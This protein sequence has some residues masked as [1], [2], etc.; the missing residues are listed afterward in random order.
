MGKYIKIDLILLALF[1]G[2]ITNIVV[3][4]FVDVNNYPTTSLCTGVDALKTNVS[5]DEGVIAYKQGFPFVDK[6][7]IGP[8]NYEFF[9]R[10]RK[11]T[12]NMNEFITQINHAKFHEYV[13][14]YKV[15]WFR[16]FLTVPGLRL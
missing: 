2:F 15:F 11:N 14:I 8:D 9:D 10:C 5:S 4:R 13:R 12:P 6:I 3:Y 16:L 7:E 1:A